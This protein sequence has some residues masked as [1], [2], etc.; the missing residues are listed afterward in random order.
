MMDGGPV[1]DLQVYRAVR[2]SR[3][4]EGFHCLPSAAERELEND[5]DQ[6]ALLILDIRGYMAAKHAFDNA[7]DKVDGLKGWAGNPYMTLVETITFEARQAPR[8]AGDGR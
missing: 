8:A 3:V 2:A 6:L 4:C 1:T 7:V 5:P